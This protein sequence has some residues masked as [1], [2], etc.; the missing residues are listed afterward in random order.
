MKAGIVKETRRNTIPISDFRHSPFSFF[1]A[2]GGR[3]IRKRDKRKDGI[4]RGIHDVGRQINLPTS[5]I[6]VI[7]DWSA[8]HTSRWVQRKSLYYH[9]Q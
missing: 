8:W 5:S 7:N 3:G 2:D 6:L 9:R 1:L 4:R